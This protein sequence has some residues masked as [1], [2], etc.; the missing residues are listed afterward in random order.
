MHRLGGTVHFFEWLLLRV[1]APWISGELRMAVLRK[2][3]VGSMIAGATLIA[4]AGSPLPV[5]LQARRPV[6]HQL[7]NT[8][9]RVAATPIE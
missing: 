1:V 7:G 6:G 5:L 9:I 4:G 2:F 8:K 3:V